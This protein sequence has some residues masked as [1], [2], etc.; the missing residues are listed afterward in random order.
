M[1][2]KQNIIEPKTKFNYYVSV[3]VSAFLTS[4][5]FLLEFRVCFAYA[6]RFF[7]AG[8]LKCPFAVIFFL[9][10]SID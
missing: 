1:R 4:C 5:R 7:Q 9:F 10:L 3:K 2:G 6:R 8:T